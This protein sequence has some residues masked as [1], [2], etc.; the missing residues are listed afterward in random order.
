MA[1]RI[2]V[3]TMVVPHD[4]LEIAALELAEKLANGPTLA[5]QKTKQVIYEGL[6][7]D[8][9]ESLKYINVAMQ[10]LNQTR[11]HQEGAT[12]FVEKRE[13]EFRGE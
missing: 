12:A 1:K 2:G 6:R 5:I 10:E 13:P 4:E 11:D 8:L 3:V 9:E 7:M